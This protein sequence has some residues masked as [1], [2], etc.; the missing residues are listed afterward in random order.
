[1]RHGKP[2]W[3]A[4][5]AYFLY[6]NLSRKMIPQEKSTLL[7]S[8]LDKVKGALGLHFLLRFFVMISLYDWPGRVLSLHQ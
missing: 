2:V 8:R 7:I 4:R 1:M 6:F 5:Q 3:L